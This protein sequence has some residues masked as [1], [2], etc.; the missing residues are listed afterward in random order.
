MGK[1]LEPRLVA[2]EDGG[3][4]VAVWG[5]LRQELVDKVGLAQL[6]RRQVAHD[7]D[8]RGRRARHERLQPRQCHRRCGGPRREEESVALADRAPR[9]H[10]LCVRRV[11]VIP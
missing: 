8:E 10:K 6:A 1:H 7:V 3:A 9:P 4:R 5:A 11:A 2:V